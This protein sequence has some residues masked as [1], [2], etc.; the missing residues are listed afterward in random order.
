MDKLLDSQS[1]FQEDEM[2]VRL[3]FQEDGGLTKEA[4]AAEIDDFVKAIE[5]REGFF[6]LHINAMGAG[7]WYGSN[8]NGDYF[9]ESQLIKWHKT[10]E[11][12]PAH[13]FRHHVNKD[14]AIAIGKVIFSYYNPRM[15]RVELVAEVDKTKASAEYSRIMAGDFPM[16]SMACHTPFDVCSVCGNKAT[17]RSM[18]CEHLNNHLNEL[19]PDGRKV[20]SLN[21]GPLKFFDISIVIRPADVTSSVLQKVAS[22]VS[23]IGS[24]EQAEMEGVQFEGRVKSASLKKIAVEKV[25]DLIKHI[26]GEVAAGAENLDTILDR[27]VD[28]DMDII[29]VLCQ[30]SVEDLANAFAELGI[31]PSLEFLAT[32]LVSKGAGHE[33]SHLGVEAIKI[34]LEMGPEAL[35]QEH[36]IL[37]PQVEEKEANPLLVKLLTK[38]IEGSSLAPSVVEKRA[39]T[40]VMPPPTRPTGYTNFEPGRKPIEKPVIAAP[41]EQ[42][43]GLKLLLT[44]A[45]SALVLKYV[46]N[47]LV[48][49]KLEKAQSWLKSSVGNS[50]TKSASI[51][52]K[53]MNSSVEREFAK[54]DRKRRG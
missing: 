26:D 24:V 47:S 48:Q 45:G 49:S 9:P 3:L 43:S 4:A 2:Q 17:S 21:V 40:Y 46:I 7:E 44:V 41:V 52:A 5:P 36:F 39:A 15:H 54:A 35:T 6:Y 28:P 53:L 34:L 11:T 23:A 20:M 32:L 10:F 30:Y 14:P 12:S 31:S 33:H 22:D 27:V 19:L 8:R 37:V 18:Y 1:F 25:A 51:T 50:F 38:F 29:P 16:T 13:V 42:P